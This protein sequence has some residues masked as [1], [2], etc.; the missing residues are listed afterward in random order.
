MRI[1][2]YP[3]IF[4]L[5]Q[6]ETLTLDLDER[7]FTTSDIALVVELD[8]QMK[9]RLFRGNFLEWKAEV[10]AQR[11][12]DLHVSFSKSLM[13][14]VLNRYVVPKGEFVAIPLLERLHSKDPNIFGLL[15]LTDE[16]Y[17]AG[18][19]L[20]T[21]GLVDIHKRPLSEILL[22]NIRGMGFVRNDSCLTTLRLTTT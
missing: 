8:H 17:E 9:D 20:G 7:I 15:E 16:A 12:M 18:Y 6:R 10:H 19:R 21:S 1:F 2:S 4:D 14:T 3:E 11:E 13:R 5:F 22:T